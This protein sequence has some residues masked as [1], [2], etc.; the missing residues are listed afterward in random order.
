MSLR[1]FNYVSAT[2]TKQQSLT[3]RS[4]LTIEDLN[5]S[6]GTF[7]DGQSIQGQK[8]VVSTECTEVT[9][10][11]C[12]DIFRYALQLSARPGNV[13][14]DHISELPGFQWSSLTHSAA[15]N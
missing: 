1:A 6:K 4:Q 10:G 9:L 7:I 12:P 13:T 5:T 3:S 11:K 15:E 8:H 2:N 14:D